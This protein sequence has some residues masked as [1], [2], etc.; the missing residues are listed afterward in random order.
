MG[1]G[2]RLIAVTGEER[3]VTAAG[4][5][6]AAYDEAIQHVWQGSRNQGV[7]S[8]PLPCDMDQAMAC[9]CVAVR[10]GVVSGL[11]DNTGSRQSMR[12]GHA[13]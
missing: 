1:L 9:R 2:G 7:R 10:K 6:R 8:D 13:G 3:P 4:R 11:H 12:L 5:Y